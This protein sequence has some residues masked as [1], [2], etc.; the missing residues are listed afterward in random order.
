MKT[1]RSFWV[2]I[3]ASAL[4]LGGGLIAPDPGA[5]LSS[6]P[7]SQRGMWLGSRPVEFE[8][9][10]KGIVGPWTKPALLLIRDPSEWARAMVR[11]GAVI[12]V[13][14]PRIDWSRKAIV[15]AVLGEQPVL[16]YRIE[17]SQALRHAQDLLLKVHIQ[18]PDGPNY[19]QN[20]S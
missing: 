15:L 9:I 16:G 11:A 13:P 17:V 20:F 19:T 12:S 10:D 6:D 2:P 4:L 5:A 8:T 7:A 1:A 3:V 18:L 14:P